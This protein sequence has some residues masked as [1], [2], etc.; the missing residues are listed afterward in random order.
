[1]PYRKLMVKKLALRK[2][3]KVKIAN[4]AQL[5]NLQNCK[6]R[7]RNEAVPNFGDL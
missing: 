5:D 7:S 6:T 3:R 2:E 1:M 4:I